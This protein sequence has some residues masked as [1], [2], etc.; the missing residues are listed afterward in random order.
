M[1]RSGLGF[2]P[3]S[4]GFAVILGGAFIALAMWTKKKPYSAI[5]TGLIVF[6]GYLLL[7]IA[8]NI[9]IDGSVGLLK[10]IF[11]GIVIKVIILVNLILPIKAAKEL[12]EAKN[13]RF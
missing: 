13:K 8:A 5:I 1:I 2:D 11:G 3:V 10:G 9:L 12:Q 6:I 7:V 4:V